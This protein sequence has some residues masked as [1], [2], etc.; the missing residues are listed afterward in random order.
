M[1]VT[2]VCRLG[3]LPVK[4]EE[5]M[6]GKSIRRE[7]NALDHMNP[8]AT[9]VVSAKPVERGQ[10]LSSPRLIR[11]HCGL[12]SAFLADCDGSSNAATASAS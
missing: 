2:S 1:P 7:C 3:K 5:R 6:V 9:W 11:A 4:P 12:S 8:L 10:L